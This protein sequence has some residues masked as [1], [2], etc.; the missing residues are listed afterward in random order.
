MALINQVDQPVIEKHNDQEQTLS[1]SEVLKELSQT[2]RDLQ[3]A[4]EEASHLESI[5]G[6]LEIFRTVLL[7][8]FFFLLLAVM[9]YLVVD[10][11]NE[12]PIIIDP[13]A[14]PE[15]LAE[16]GY[17]PDIVS[18]RIMAKFRAIQEE[19]KT[20]SKIKGDLTPEW[21]EAD[22]EV[23]GT[24]F[25]IDSAARFVR[26][27]FNFPVTRIQ[28]E[29]TQT[30]DEKLQIELRVSGVPSGP[31]TVSSD[32][33]A[34]IDRLVDQ[35]ALKLLGVIDPY[36]LAVHLYNQ[37]E[38]DAAKSII[39]QM[40]Q[41]LPEDDDPWAY[42]LW[43]VMLAEEGNLEN[44]TQM[45]QKGL[46][47]DPSLYIVYAHW[48]VALEEQEDFAGAVEK[49][50]N[51]AEHEDT[52]S[53]IN[54]GVMYEEGL[55]VE[56]NYEEASRLY[57]LAAEN[58]ETLGYVN[59][60]VM[61]EHGTGV[62]ASNEEAVRFYRLAAE[63]GDATGQAYLGN[64][65]S[66]GLGVEQ[67]YA[68]AVRFYRLAAEQDHSYADEGQVALG[69]MYEQGLGV[70]QNYE[71]AAHWYGLAVEWNNPA[72]QYYFGALYENGHGVDQDYEEAARLYL[73]AAEQGDADAQESLAVMYE[74]GRG[75]PKDLEEAEQWRSM[76]EN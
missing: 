46:E 69:L 36:T 7:N 47:I 76:S 74:E 72:A 57:Q 14:V 24:E 33:A 43:G 26:N 67:N 63:L 13:I 61:Y 6:K 32:E 45:Y 3:P 29:M 25:T 64:M 71:K 73:L 11:L 58:G 38:Y 18:V 5:N 49:Y 39:G 53:Q 30:N 50:R 35:A 54:L 44:A 68:E 1:L 2:L 65:Y 19:T 37:Q 56:Q 16:K 23:P 20:P 70:E 15:A 51:G 4:L 27:V 48:G 40:L 21:T 10:E 17:T 41:T 22:L 52:W 75:V 59:L 8:G 42:T 55:G 34:P 12:V 28:G 62:E 31:Q 60:G 66:E 9:G